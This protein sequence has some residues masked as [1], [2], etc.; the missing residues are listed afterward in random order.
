PD[1]WQS[2]P[3]RP[4]FWEELLGY[5]V[6]AR[7]EERLP[8]LYGVLRLLGLLESRWIEPTTPGRVAYQRRTVRWDRLAGLAANPRSLF[9]SVYGWGTQNFDDR[10]LMQNVAELLRGF[11]LKPDLISKAPELDDYFD[12]ATPYRE[13]IQ[14]LRAL[15][16][17]FPYVSDT[18][19]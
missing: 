15:L 3:G 11:G 5:L 4:S 2:V 10:Q 17:W 12:P 13:Q 6:Y 1:F 8:Q 9:A 7:I 14:T 19:I 18:A 16:A